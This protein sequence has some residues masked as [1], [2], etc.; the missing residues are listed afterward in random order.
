MKQLLSY[1]FQFV[2]HIQPVLDRKGEIELF[3]P[4]AKFKNSSGLELHKYGDG[5][6]CRFS[7][8][9]NK[10]AGVSGVYAYFIDDTLVYIGQALDLLQRFNRGYSY[11]AP[12][13]CFVGGESTNCKMNKVVLEAASNH[14]TVS[15]YFYITGDFHRV[16]RELIEYF[17]PVYNSVLRSEPNRTL[18]VKELRSD[19]RKNQKITTSRG[20]TNN[21]SIHD[22]RSHIQKLIESAK[23]QGKHELTI[24]S[25]EI[26]AS[27]NMT[28]ALPTVCSAMRTLN[29]Q[30]DYV[31]IDQPPKGNGSW[32]VFKYLF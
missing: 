9:P 25:G 6:F 30:Y 5:A 28:S 22:V 23:F 17:N 31:V 13:S 11:I 21:P 1:E 8:D 15:L 26:H 3:Y 18:P 32:L 10:W 29:G 27:L 2:Q 19:T 24:R 20:K 12:R 4:Q 7:I 16:E 14:K